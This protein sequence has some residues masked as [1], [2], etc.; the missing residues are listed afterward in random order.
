[1]MGYGS[2]G[3]GWMWMVIGVVV[4]IGVVVWTAIAMTHRGRG[5]E[6]TSSASVAP[7]RGGRARQILDERYARGEMTS[8]EYTER[9]RTLGL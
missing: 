6:T 5:Y 3:S 8:D 7:D 2:G 9:L 1:M 4:L